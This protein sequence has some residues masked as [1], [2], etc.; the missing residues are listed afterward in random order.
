MICKAAN[1]LLPRREGQASTSNQAKRRYITDNP[2]GEV[3]CL[4]MYKQLLLHV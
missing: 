2:G 3:H 1:F 4:Y